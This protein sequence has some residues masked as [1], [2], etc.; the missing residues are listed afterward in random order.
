MKGFGLILL[1][2]LMGMPEI[3]ADGVTCN[4]RALHGRIGMMK[5]M[6]TMIGAIAFRHLVKNVWLNAES[7]R[8]SMDALQR[9]KDD[10]LQ[11]ACS[12]LSLAALGYVVLNLASESVHSLSIFLKDDE[13][14]EGTA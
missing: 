14:T 4:E 10:S 2:V 12:L 13:E 9:P 1:A 11:R 8:A 3:V 6:G 7:V 5:G